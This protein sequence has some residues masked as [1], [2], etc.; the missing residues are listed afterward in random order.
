MNKQNGSVGRDHE[1]CVAAAVSGPGSELDY[2]WAVEQF[3]ESLYKFAFGLAGNESDAKDLTQ[4]TFRVLLTKGGQIRDA[5]KI[6]SWLFTTLHRQFLS[7]HRHCARFPELELE[8]AELPVIKANQI[9][10]ADVGI[11]MAAFQALDEKYRAPLAMFYLEEMS[12]REIAGVLGIPPGTVMSRL[13]RGKEQ[14]KQ[15]LAADKNFAQTNE[16][17][18]RQQCSARKIPVAWNVS[19]WKTS[20]TTDA[21]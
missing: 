1:S 13:S 21:L 4:E 8:E 9:A 16:A 12:Y 14:L 18:I 15:Q 17:E 20:L 6:K 19:K 10:N 11:V 7:R 3:Y 2:G 5:S